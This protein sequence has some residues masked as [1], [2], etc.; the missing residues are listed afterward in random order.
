ML[1][2]MKKRRVDCASGRILM[3]ATIVVVLSVSLFT[4]EASAADVTLADTLNKTITNVNWADSNPLTATWGIILANKNMTAL[5]DAINQSI[6]KS[7]YVNALHIAR[8]A[9][10]NQYSS[11]SISQGAET[12]LQQISMCGSLPIN[13]AANGYGDP[14][15]TNK[16][17]FLVYN[18]FLIWAY[19]FAEEY[20]LTSKWDKNRAF[21]DFAR[22][23]NKPPAN[24][25]SGEMLWCDPHENWANSFSSR[26]YDE[27]AETLSV[28]LKFY[29]IGVQE[30]LAYTDK[31]WI[32]VQSHWNGQY[33]GYTGS[34]NVECEMGSFARII[35][36]YRQEKGG[37][38]SDWERVI[39]DLNYKLLAKGWSSPGWASPGVIVH[40][41]SNSQLR[42]WETLSAITTLHQ[43]FPQLT[44]NMKQS[45]AD[46][47]MGQTLAWKGLIESGLNNNGYFRGVYPGS[48]SSN[49]ATACA[50]ATL[51]LEGIVPITGSLAIPLLEENYPPDTTPFP[52]REMK[53]DYSNH[54][55]KIPVKAGELT[56]VYGSLPVSYNFTSDGVYDIEFTDDWNQITRVNGEPVAI[57][58]TE[59]QKLD[60]AEGNF[61][62][63]LSWSPSL[64]SGDSKVTNY[65]IYK[66]NTTNE[67]AFFAEVGN[68]L[69]FID[70]EV[71]KGEA[72]YYR[73]T[74][75]SPV[76]ESKP[77]NEANVALSGPT[78]TDSYDGLWHTEDFTI[79][80]KATDSS[81]VSEIYY[82]INSGEAQNVSTKGQPQITFESGANVLE[83]WSIDTLGNEELPH[84]ILTQVKLDKTA[85]TGSLQ[86]NEGARATPSTSV[87]LSITSTD[88][89]SGIYQVRFSNDGVWD[90]EQW[91]TPKSIETWIL[92]SEDGA[93][94]VY[95]EIRDNAGLVSVSYSDTIILDTSA[96]E[97]SMQIND[98]TAYL[99]T[100]AVQLHLS[101]TDAGSGVVQM[102]FS[103]DNATWSAWEHYTTSKSWNLQEGDGPKSVTVQYRDDAGTV[104]SYSDS[105]NLDT[106]PPEAN[107]GPDRKVSTGS[108]LSFEARN[109]TD[110][111]DTVG[112]LWNFG[113]GTLGNG[114]LTNHTYTNPGTY[115]V[116]LI[117]EDAAGNNAQSIITVIV[118]PLQPWLMICIVTCS[119]L[120]I[121][122]ITAFS[123][124]KKV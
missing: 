10:L 38:F 11:T 28:F 19:K 81:G 101:A 64:L 22:M 65:R 24:S 104:S 71:S 62:I 12:A 103:N 118:Q 54:K 86:I 96:P 23:S 48:Q 89:T 82:R 51:F 29:E 15:L 26:Y 112:Y 124:R 122:F 113:D 114:R 93:K 109:S 49:E 105:T 117:V 34:S 4:V 102:R 70:N 116:Q 31:A 83:Y 56:F 85:P 16:G 108:F 20:N 35:G 87:T 41:E 77:S 5:D 67:E 59:P 37:N 91:Q 14:D 7:N 74:A 30:A 92:D 43:L 53:F 88:A 111:A 47:L 68:T 106:T 33:Y 50:A 17:C 69:S 78:T 66:G 98:G 119:V 107:A 97:G 76:G 27:H 42:L 18:R 61:S 6:A 46:L 32:G 8:L 121:I 13:F 58:P 25:A 44:S 1:P 99:N 36:E 55:I 21:A 84:K 90:V 123:I 40:A 9:E 45:F 110:H 3:V 63:S 2:P 72:Y 95:C 73:I 79:Y 60:A 52:V 57:T 94:T 39:Q 120:A 80:L 75:V 100:T 115:T